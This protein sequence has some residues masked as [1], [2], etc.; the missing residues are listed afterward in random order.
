MARIDREQVLHVAKLARLTLREEELPT[1]TAQLEKILG[2]IAQLGE[3][4][5]KDVEPTAQV[6]VDR[7]PLR[8]DVPREGVPREAALA[9]A[10]ETAGGGFVVPSF[11]ED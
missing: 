7:L 4:D 8:P 10:P 11:I 3:I 5:T 6:G 2:H 9:A 1:V